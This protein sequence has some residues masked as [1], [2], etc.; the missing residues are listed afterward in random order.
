MT[1]DN[2]NSAPAGGETAA[3]PAG[4]MPSI[5]SIDDAAQRWMT[6]EEPETENTVEA[7]PVTPP[8]PAQTPEPTA[9]AAVEG[10]T[11]AETGQTQPDDVEFIDWDRIS[12]EKKMRLR[13]GFEFDKR[14]INENIDK[15][16]KLPEIERNLTA[17]EQQ[18]R[19]A[20]AQ[21]VQREQQLAQVLPLAIASAQASIPPEPELPEYD[22][23]NPVGYIEK[24]AA[25]A[26]AVAYRNHKIEE[27]RALQWTE[28]QRVQE[29]QQAQK[30]QNQAYLVEQQQALFQ[31]LPRLR[32]KAEREKFH[33]D[34]VQ[35]A[36]SLGFA[37]QEYG[38][39]TDHRVML[40]A[41]LAMDG[42]KYRKL[43]SEPPKPK[44]A[45]APQAQTPPVAEPG[46]RQTTA[47]ATEARRQ[48][49]LS[50]AR[51]TGGSVNDIARLVA[52]LD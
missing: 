12:P 44:P 23:N 20:L 27:L 52:E 49:L 38:N 18:F 50:R 16:R 13:D 31:A 9:E 36:E 15:I 28:A 14:F 19:D 34:Y 29:Q 46:K 11:G 25:Y 26:Q 5:L 48:E 33:S 22:P 1:T 4:E 41:D 3:A 32:D 21:H 35:L 7:S 30:A 2:A 40:M 42:I 10:E 45:A 6:N 17:R 51:R 47:E 43:K 39:A 24:Q 37:P 8:E